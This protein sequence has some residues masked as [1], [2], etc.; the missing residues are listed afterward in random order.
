MK[1]VVQAEIEYLEQLNLV[2]K[3][4]KDTLNKK[5]A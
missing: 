3:M 4:V 5:T 1:K 2:K